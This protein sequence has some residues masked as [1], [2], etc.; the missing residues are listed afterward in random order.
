MF[1]A[2][3]TAGLAGCA[4]PAAPAAAPL[5]TRSPVT[6]IAPA[7]AEPPG[8]S[9]GV[10]PLTG[11]PAQ[12]AEHRSRAAVAVAVDLAATPPRG[13]ERADLVYEEIAPDGT[14]TALVVLQSNDAQVGPVAELRPLYPKLAVLLR[15][16]MSHTGG[17]A[18][19]VRQLDGV[20]VDAGPA[21]TTGAYSDVDA[22]PVVDT[23]VVRQASPEAVAPVPVLTYRDPEMPWRVGESATALAVA[24]P[25]HD[26]VTWAYDASSGLWSRGGG[27]ATANVLVLTVAFQPLDLGSG[28]TVQAAVLKGEGAAV[29]LSGGRRVSATWRTRGPNA[30]LNLIDSGTQEV[31]RLAPGPTWIALVPAGSTMAPTP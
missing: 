4:E 31:V 20:A 14:D 6:S 8:P 30:A 27:T 9:S 3:V 23:A 25:G 22:V 21:V 28:T 2:A 26:P 18:R 17:P 24:V 10:L 13:L 5:P 12:S 19:F 16:L 7:Q 29:V 15:P 1:A 11:S